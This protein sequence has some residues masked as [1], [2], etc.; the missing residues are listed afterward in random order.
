M[1]L[2]KT[3]AR[4]SFWTLLDD[5]LGFISGIGCS[6]AVARVLGPAKLGYYNYVM[7]IAAMAGWIAAFGIP[8]A[9][10]RYAG[11]AYGRG[12]YAQA[13][14]IVRITFRIQAWFA[15]V[16]TIIGAA[17]VLFVVPRGHRDYA[18]LAVLSIFP[19]L[20]MSIPS[21]AITATED[22]LP[23]VKASVF[24]TSTN[25]VGVVLTLVLGWDLVGLAGTILAARTIDWIVR[26]IF[27]RRIYAAL[28]IEE[29]VVQL[30]KET[31]RRMIRFCWQATALTALQIVVWERSEV[32]F[33]EHYATILD[34]A[35]YSVAF[36]ISQNLLLLPRVASM[37]TAATLNVQ[38]GRDP[39]ETVPV[40]IGTT[41]VLAV[42]CTPACF[43]L[44]ALGGPLIHVM[45]GNR[46][47]AAIPLLILLASTTIGKALQ[48]PAR[49]LLMATEH[50]GSLVVW[51]VVL[52]VLNLGLD[53]LLVPA[54]GAMGAAIA[55][56]T[57]QVLG[58]ISVWWIVA[59]IFR[60]SLPLAKFVR[61]LVASAIMGGAV[62]GLAVHLPPLIALLVGAPVGVVLLVI[63][64]RVLGCL[65]PRDEAPLKA[66]QRALPVRLR[67]P[68][69][70]ALR[71]LYPPRATESGG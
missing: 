42:V 38:Q 65:D 50:Q 35:F 36:N 27:F 29:G 49:Q 59:R 46:Y 15:V 52:A 45:Y 64:L 7:W 61:L 1:G 63:L 18:T 32:L 13:R 48:L 66:I 43:G 20:L 58:V 12:D 2:A 10:R 51:S 54:K 16:A 67:G 14:L 9:T 26:H 41:R 23:N 57:V 5:L 68:Y 19:Y 71:F 17:I 44:A 24:S 53:F 3:I 28:P 40:A 56:S 21:A 33:L 30:D 34:I 39:S 22:V 11:E 4:N 47:L 69:L 70:Y 62:Y 25:L 8:A 6:V 60:V 31:R 37:A 55:M